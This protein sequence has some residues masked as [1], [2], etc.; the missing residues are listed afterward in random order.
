M[1]DPNGW[2]APESHQ[3]SWS[4]PEAPGWGTPA[5]SAPNHTV[6]SPATTPVTNPATPRTAGQATQPSTTPGQYNQGWTQPP[7][8]PSMPSMPPA[9]GM[10]GG[11]GAAWSAAAQ[12]GII[13][14]RPLTI[15]DLFEGTFRSIRTNPAVVFGFAFAVTA[16][17]AALSALVYYFIFSAMETSMGLTDPQASIDDELTFIASELGG[18]LVSSGVLMIFSLLS[19][20]LLVGILSVAVSEA[21]LGSKP[22]FSEAWERFKPRFWPLV[23]T[24]VVI[25]VV[26]TAAMLVILGIGFGLIF[27]I[28]SGF[29]S[30][31]SG[32]AVVGIVLVILVLVAVV[33]I[34]SF[35]L[36]VKLLYAPITT[37]LEG[38]GPV[39]SIKRAWILTKGSFWRTLGRLILV[40]L[41]TGAI[42]SF[43]SYGVGIIAGIF[44][45][46]TSLVV[47]QVIT[48]FITSLLQAVVVPVTTSYEVLMY[49][50]ERFRKENLAPVLA[51]AA[52]QR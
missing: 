38:L 34:A 45:V 52:A 21:V 35:G 8:S 7:V 20:I 25:S 44:A 24:V 5:E 4:A 41:L 18:M 43:V 13:P 22:T 36:Q 39:A 40:L 50:D 29:S 6:S 27:A 47:A 14:L 16:V 17:V 2:S 42:T 19:S 15:G 12:P 28:T 3:G 37:V 32:G 48:V 51:Q 30:D 31:V 46:T 10:P 1:S 9:P 33:F 26:T 23:G 11:Y 49:L